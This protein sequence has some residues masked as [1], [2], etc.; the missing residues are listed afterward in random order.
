MKVNNECLNTIEDN[1][2]ALKATQAQHSERMDTK[3]ETLK[4][5]YQGCKWMR[6]MLEDDP[7]L[8]HH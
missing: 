4:L 7:K 3:D 2:E 8:D 5:L 6:G 1:I